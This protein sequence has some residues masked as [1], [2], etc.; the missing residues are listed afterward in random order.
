MHSELS[1]Y[2]VAAGIDQSTSVYLASAPPN[3]QGTN[4][5]LSGPLDRRIQVVV[6]LL[7]SNSHKQIAVEEMA[8]LV[9]LSPGRLA[10]LFKSEMEL[11]IQRYLTQLRLAKAKTHLESSFLSIKEIAA[12]V[13]FSSV[14]R[15][16][17]CFKN[18]V[19]ATPAQYR[20]HFPQASYERAEITP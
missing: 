4:T 1:N 15:F 20:K 7:E 11:S 6:M 17:V 3:V 16:V 10:H 2:R 13:G 18:L 12:S 19:G 14:T 5:N 8:R 9:N